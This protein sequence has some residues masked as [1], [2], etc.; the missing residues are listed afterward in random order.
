MTRR[1]D[2]IDAA[3]GIAILL[4]VFGHSGHSGYIRDFIYTFHVPFFFFV[5]GL[6]IK[7]IEWSGIKGAF[8]NNLRRLI[9][10]YVAM[11]LLT[12]P[13][14]LAFIYFKDGLELSFSN[15]VIKPLMGMLWGVDRLQGEYTMFTNGPLWFLVALFCARM[16]F[17]LNSLVLNKS[18]WGGVILGVVLSIVMCFILGA[19]GVNVWS[20]RQAL[21]LYPFLLLGFVSQRSFCI[22][23]KIRDCKRIKAIC[24]SIIL[25]AIVGAIVPC[26]GTIDYNYLRLGE[27][28]LLSYGIASLSC[29]ALMLLSR[30][31]PIFKIIGK[32]TIVI[33]GFHHPVMDII[34]YCALTIG[35][36]V[37]DYSFFTCFL[38][39]VLTIIIC[40][41]LFLLILS[42]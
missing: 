33:L 42:T 25:F 10:P 36:K 26:L 41:C 15:I 23:E 2:F 37:Y 17:C 8:V 9:V 35:V 3:K 18:N 16:L 38:I 1:I 6:F 13:F 28:P 14:G 24:I 20:L 29:F 19:C 39:S 31:I 7:P 11:Y 27:M 40:H 5:S 30:G 32:S 21:L 12:I 4:V 34:K 22:V